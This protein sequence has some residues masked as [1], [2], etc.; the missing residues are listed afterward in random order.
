MNI[1]YLDAYLLHWPYSKV[2][3]EETLGELA[4][5]YGKTVPQI[6]IRWILQHGCVPPPGS[7][8]NVE[9]MEQNENVLDFTLSEE[10]MTT[11]DNH[12]KQSTRKMGVKGV[13]AER[14][15]FSDEFDF[16]YEQCWPKSV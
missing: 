10:E 12:A 3:I 14:E 7:K 4:A 2:P 1:D 11:I 6:A 15:G 8:N 13:A 9:H 5:K 16:S